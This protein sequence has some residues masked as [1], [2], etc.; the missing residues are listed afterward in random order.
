M[1]LEEQVR[2]AADL[3]ADATFSRQEDRA[4]QLR[5]SLGLGQPWSPSL[6]T[7]VIQLP[8]LFPAQAPSGFDTV[9]AI[10]R[11]GSAPGGTGMRQVGQEIWMHF[12]WNPSGAIDYTRED[13]VWRFAKFAESRFLT[14]Q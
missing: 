6:V 7:A 3:L 2:Y 14:L 4:Y 1:T 8:P 9:G 11:A 12:C 13:A 10:S 5:W